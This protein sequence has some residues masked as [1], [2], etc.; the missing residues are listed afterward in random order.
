MSNTQD[1]AVFKPFASN[2]NSWT[3]D[4]DKNGNKIFEGDLL[5]CKAAVLLRVSHKQIY[6]VTRFSSGE[7]SA[8]VPEPPN[9]HYSCMFLLLRPRHIP[10]EWEIVGNIHEGIMLKEQEA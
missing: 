10:Y 7:W 8:I 4:L 5:T 6:L 1:I 2:S 3:G 9:S